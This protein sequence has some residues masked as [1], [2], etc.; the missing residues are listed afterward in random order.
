MAQAWT[1]SIEVVCDDIDTFV[2]LMHFYAQVQ[3]ISNLK[4]SGTFTGRAVIYIKATTMK[5]ATIADQLLP[6]HALTGCDTATQLYAI[7]QG[8]VIMAKH[9]RNSLNHIEKTIV[10]MD[11]VLEEAT[12]VMAFC[13]RSRNKINMSA[14]RF[15]IWI[16]KANW[17]LTSAPM[18]NTLP[19]TTESFECHVHQLIPGSYLALWSST[20]TAKSESNLFWMV[21]RCCYRNTWLCTPFLLLYL[22]HH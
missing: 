20:R 4:I 17:K 11:R 18:L 1:R 8:T 13:Y 19:P 3:L 16:C 10:H 5:H 14:A 21:T 6:A 22:L 7:R 9:S 12:S 15:G 2:L